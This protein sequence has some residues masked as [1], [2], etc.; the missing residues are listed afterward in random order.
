MKEEIKNPLNAYDA[1]DSRPVG[2]G[3]KKG[4]LVITSNFDER[5]I[6]GSLNIP[7]TSMS[8]TSN[9]NSKRSGY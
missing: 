9:T 4:G 2:G 6:Q 7:L 5:P 1:Y 3:T 8:S